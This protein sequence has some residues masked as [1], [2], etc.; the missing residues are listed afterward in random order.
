M[1]PIRRY[2]RSIRG[3]GYYLKPVH[4][5]VK[6]TPGGKRVFYYFG[7]YWYTILYLGRDGW[8]KTRLKWVYRGRETPPGLP[9]P[10]PLPLEGA[11]LYHYWGEPTLVYVAKAPGQGGV[12]KVVRVLGELGVL[13]DVGEGV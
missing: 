1:E 5:V 4:Q 10:P 6:K 7:R 11:S 8:G 13:I 2:N 3:K 12:E 9:P